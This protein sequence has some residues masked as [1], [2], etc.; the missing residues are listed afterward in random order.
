MIG[1]NNWSPV[2]KAGIVVLILILGAAG[3][4]IA[5]LQGKAVVT[6]PLFLGMLGVLTAANLWLLIA[7]W[8]MRDSLGRLMQ[9]ALIVWGGIVMWYWTFAPIY[10]LLNMNLNDLQLTW[11]AFAFL[12]EVPVIGGGVLTTVA[13]LLFRPIAQ[14]I[15]LGASPVASA[16]AYKRALK[17]P[18]RIATVLFCLSVIGYVIG[19][20]QLE[21]FAGVSDLELLKSVSNGPVISV[22]LAVFYYLTFDTY[23]DQ[24]RRQ[25]TQQSVDVPLPVRSLRRRLA[26]VGLAVLL[27]AFGLLSILLID[28]FQRLAEHRLEA[29]LAE[30][31]PEIRRV[32][33]ENDQEEIQS[34]ARGSQGFITTVS[35]T[36]IADLSVAEE[37]QT[38]LFRQTEGIIIDRHERGKILAF[39]TPE[40]TEERVVSVAYLI[41]FYDFLRFSEFLPS[42]LASLLVILLTAGIFLFVVYEITRALISLRLLAQE[43]KFSNWNELVGVHTGDEI[44]GVGRSFMVYVEKAQEVDKV[45]REFVSI[46]SHQLRTPLTTIRW[47][48]ELL[49]GEKDGPLTAKQ[50]EDVQ[51][52][53]HGSHRMIQLVN[54]L[55]NVSRVDSGRLAIEPQETDLAEFIRQLIDE[56]TPQAQKLECALV[57]EKNT[58]ST[59]VWVDQVLLRQVIHNLFTNAI[60]YRF[61]NRTCQV[62]ITLN[63]GD[64]GQFILLIKDNGIGIP[65]E[66]QHR[67]FDQ[68]FRADNV[69]HLDTDGTGLGL[70]VSKMLL[71]AAGC[72]ITF[73]SEEGKGTTFCITIPKSGMLAKPGEIGL[74]GSK[75]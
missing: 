65:R 28:S 43:P 34:L 31:I 61:P 50:K 42:I 68:F 8:K 55:L 71:E 14:S 5:A 58:Q 16:H 63:Q 11:T 46:A 45:K 52:I 30:D 72:N 39:I 29:E 66:Q 73:S 17:Y 32:V 9:I 75:Q 1:M 48:I 53:A 21:L 40:N 59:S 57:V 51:K 20:L 36:N 69:A 74:A 2:T 7:A 23:L 25:L 56:I 15:S 3:Y 37:T 64:L 33:T 38:A 62:S 10:Y 49:A 27:G 24:H 60:K 22:F 47:Y 4:T 54:S 67:V 26:T 19:A 12:W 18:R 13:V 41:D 6:L 35:K 70:Y 44:E